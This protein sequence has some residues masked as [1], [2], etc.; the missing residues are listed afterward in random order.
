M[1]TKGFFQEMSTF[2]GKIMTSNFGS[3]SIPAVDH[4][5]PSSNIHNSDKGSI[6][7]MDYQIQLKNILANTKLCTIW[8]ACTLIVMGLAP[9]TR[10]ANLW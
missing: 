6:C 1:N 2:F 4:V 9:K 7:T 10:P 8:Q 3:D 5:Q